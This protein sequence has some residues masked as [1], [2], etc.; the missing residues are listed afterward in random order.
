MELA[1]INGT[2]RPAAQNKLQLGKIKLLYFFF[3]FD[4]EKCSLF[5]S[6]LSSMAQPR[7]LTPGFLSAGSPMRSPALAGTPIILSPTRI[8]GTSP[9]SVATTMQSQM[10]IP[11]LV[12]A[13]S[14]TA[15][16]LHQAAAAQ[17]LYR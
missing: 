6:A 1:I 4:F 3:N 14:L 10:G 2:Y 7:L 5:F 13:G 15:A 8:A 16:D 17:L 9:S 11:S 12:P